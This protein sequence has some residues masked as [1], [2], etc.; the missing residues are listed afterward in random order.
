MWKWGL[1]NLSANFVY[2]GQTGVL[3]CDHIKET[4]NA[5]KNEEHRVVDEEEEIAF[6]FQAESA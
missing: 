3:A 2:G 6:G 1:Y 4:N 5:I